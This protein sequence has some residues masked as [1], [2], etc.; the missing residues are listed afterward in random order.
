MQNNQR[1][2]CVTYLEFHLYFNLPLLLTLGVLARKKI[3]AGHLKWIGVVLLIVIAFTYP[4]D[5]AA[6]SQG[7]WGFGRGRVA[8]W[9]GNLPFEEVLFFVLEGLA[10]SLLVITLL[11]AAD[12]RTTESVAQ[13]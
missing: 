2:D 4:W 1:T 9:I 5:S 3:R 12:T 6:V 8:A 13:R 11:P 10:V 7:I